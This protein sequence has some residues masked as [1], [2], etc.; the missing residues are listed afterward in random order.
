MEQYFFIDA[1][2]PESGLESRVD[3]NTIEAVFYTTVDFSAKLL[4]DCFI[5][6]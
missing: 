1:Y 5:L 6:H 2:Y 3:N 4:I